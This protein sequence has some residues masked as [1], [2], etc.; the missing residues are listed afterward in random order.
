MGI[1]NGLKITHGIIN[2]NGIIPN[3]TYTCFFNVIISHLTFPKKSSSGNYTQELT[4]ISFR[5]P[6]NELLEI[7]CQAMSSLPSGTRMSGMA[8]FLY[9]DMLTLACWTWL[10]STPP[11]EPWARLL[12]VN[13]SCN[14]P[15][16]LSPSCVCVS[17]QVWVAFGHQIYSLHREC[18]QNVA[19]YP[20]RAPS[21]LAI[22]GSNDATR[23]PWSS[24]VLQSLPALWNL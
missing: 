23:G 12:R 24:W 14:W 1:I 10:P 6:W 22:E 2:V 21:C 13:L 18:L 4:Y 19:N 9:V 8:V 16:P 3:P 5:G 17:V 11:V 7:C 20:R 15:S